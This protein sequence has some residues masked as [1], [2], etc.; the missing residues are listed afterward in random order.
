MNHIDCLRPWCIICLQPNLQHLVL[1]RFQR[2]HEAESH[3]KV[4]K[5]IMP[6]SS[7]T[8]MFDHASEE[9]EINLGARWQHS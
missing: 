1:N 3:L 6:A 2:R 7:Y 5:Q 9:A 4:L 8:L